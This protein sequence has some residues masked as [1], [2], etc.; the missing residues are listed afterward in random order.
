LRFLSTFTLQLGLGRP[1]FLSSTVQQDNSALIVNLTNSDIRG[2]GKILI[3]KGILHFFKSKFLSEV[4]HE[5]LTV[6]NYGSQPMQLSFSFYFDADFS[7]IFEVRGTRRLQRGHRLA[8][9]VAQ[10]EA[11][12]AYAG[13]DGVTR[14]TELHFSPPPAHMSGHRARFEL[15]LEAGES[16]Q[17]EIAI[18]CLTSECSRPVARYDDAWQKAVH[19]RARAHSRATG[20]SSSND[21]FNAWVNRSLSEV[22]MMVSETAYGPYPYA[23]VPWFSTAFGRDGIIT[24]LECLWCYPDLAAGVLRFLS[25]TQATSENRK[26]EAEP[27]KILHE[28]R[29]GEMANLG[30]T[31][32]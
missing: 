23:G 28:A 15:Q 6:T 2:D 9:T 12:L 4:C 32:C 5:R 20:L 21:Q 27:G 14:R 8:T 25:A 18:C 19:T 13:L 7:D 17:W 11:V 10:S 30:E 29:K 24:A 31:L 3:P 1:L 26:Q 22:Q 16:Q